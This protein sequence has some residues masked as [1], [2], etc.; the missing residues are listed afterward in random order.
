LP[1]KPPHGCLQ[2][3][4]A[5]VPPVTPL[6]SGAQGIT[7]SLHK[8]QNEQSLTDRYQYIKQFI[9]ILVWNLLWVD[10]RMSSEFFI[11]FYPSG[12]PERFIA[13]VAKGSQ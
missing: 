12:T 3:E 1:Q 5:R 4:W 13:F 10:S 8:K 11:V 6:D 9:S 2:K 7:P